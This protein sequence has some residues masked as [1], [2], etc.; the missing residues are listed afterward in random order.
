MVEKQIEK[1]DDNMGKYLEDRELDSV[2]EDY[3]EESDEKDETEVEV[4]KDGKEVPVNEGLGSKLDE[5]NK[6][7]LKEHQEKLV[8]KFEEA[9]KKYNYKYYCV[10]MII[11]YNNL[12]HPEAS[13]LYLYGS[14]ERPF[15]KADRGF[16]TTWKKD[17]KAKK[18]SQFSSMYIT[19]I[20]NVPGSVRNLIL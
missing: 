14:N 19:D 7:K 20:K 11:T 10:R 1:V 18:I 6:K 17:M 12:D 9:K 2:L 3:F 5:Y 4:Y 16:I 13:D 15:T 8:K